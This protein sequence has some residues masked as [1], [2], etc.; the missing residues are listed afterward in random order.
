[1]AA[2]KQNNGVLTKLH[3]F[4][5]NQS[6]IIHSLIRGKSSGYLNGEYKFDGESYCN[7]K[8]FS[9]LTDLLISDNFNSSF[10]H[11]EN[12][13][14]VGRY[15]IT[16][17]GFVFFD[18]RRW[19]TTDKSDLKSLSPFVKV[20]KNLAGVKY[21]VGLP[22]LRGCWSYQTLNITTRVEVQGKFVAAAG[23]EIKF[24]SFVQNVFRQDLLSRIF[25]LD[26]NGFMIDPLHESSKFLGEVHPDLLRV[27]VE[28]GVYRKHIHT[29]CIRECPN[30]SSLT[31]LPETTSS[32]SHP[33]SIITMIS[34]SFETIILL[35][36][37]LWH[38]LLLTLVKSQIHNT[39]SDLPLNTIRAVE[40]CQEYIHY[41]RDFLQPIKF[42]L[43]IPAQCGCGTSYFISPIPETNLL[44]VKRSANPYC[45]CKTRPIRPT[46]GRETKIYR[47]CYNSTF[48]HRFR[49]SKTCI[50][51]QG[52]LTTPGC[53]S[54]GDR[55]FSTGHC[56]YFTLL[57]ILICLRIK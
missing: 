13:G 14:V 40:C 7:T 5:C 44:S 38:S 57:V 1:M 46:E 50:P 35:L 15:V 45:G 6:Q 20:M 30:L 51:D 23:F 53:T 42:P 11:S 25:L 43:S 31:L 26:E 48:Q 16:Y 55:T 4:S 32:A 41:E 2:W 54:G 21:Y 9:V 37:V 52:N 18:N 27:L 19:N 22:A 29:E 17:N 10:L 47:M 56:K 39:P 12:L 49:P 36:H 34:S 28:G 24:S 3:K 33:F 8:I